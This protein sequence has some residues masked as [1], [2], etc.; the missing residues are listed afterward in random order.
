MD[1]VVD[2][3]CSS[4][5]IDDDMAKMDLPPAL[6]SELVLKPRREPLD[7]LIVVAVLLN[8]TLDALETKGVSPLLL[9]LLVVLAANVD[10]KRK[11]EEEE[12]VTVDEVEEDVVE[13][14]PVNELLFVNP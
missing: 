9:L 14:V 4:D 1:I 11:G 8:V 5:L 3:F 7:A 6:T 13:V 2:F 10:K 12:A